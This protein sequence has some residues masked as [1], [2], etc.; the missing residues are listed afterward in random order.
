VPYDRD[1]TLLRI[2]GLGNEDRFLI[3]ELESYLSSNYEEMLRFSHAE[4]EIRRM[5]TDN[6]FPSDRIDALLVR[7]KSEPA[8]QART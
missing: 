3:V 2:R 7:A 5:L 1:T 8:W 6:G 4:P